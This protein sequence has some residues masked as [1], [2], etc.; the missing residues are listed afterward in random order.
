MNIC[1]NVAHEIPDL[2]TRLRIQP[3]G[4]LVEKDDLGIIDQGEG[5]EESLLLSAGERHE[6]RISFVD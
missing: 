1:A 6:P 4:E 2:A 3:G 5:D